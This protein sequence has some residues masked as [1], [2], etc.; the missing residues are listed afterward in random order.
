MLS[1]LIGIFGC[2]GSGETPESDG[3]VGGWTPQELE[4]PISLTNLDFLKSALE[5]Q[6]HTL[7]DIKILS[8][9]T[10]VVSGYNIRIEVAGTY[11]G[12]YGRGVGI[13]YHDI[14][15]QKELVSWIWEEK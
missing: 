1:I 12:S 3:L 6:G 7:E 15:G 9:E 4:A 13:I 11:N 14:Q 5:N 2:Q 10:Q 8:S